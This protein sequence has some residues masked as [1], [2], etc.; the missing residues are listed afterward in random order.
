MTTQ[1]ADTRRRRAG[2]RRGHADRAGQAAIDQTP[3]RVPR[4]TDPPTEPLGPEGVEA[5][6]N[7]AMRILSEI[8][9]VF[10]NAEAREV[11]AK[12][13]A[14]LIDETVFFDPDMVMETIA[15]APASFQIVPRNTARTLTVGDGHILFGNVSSPPNA[16]DMVRGKRPGDFDSFVELIKLTQYFNCIHFAGGYPVEPIDVHASV[17]HLDCLYEKLT[18]TDKV[19]HAYSLGAER[20]EDVMEMVRIAGGLT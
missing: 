4:N 6:H 19:A 1:T 9:I 16:W 11:M 14:K 20:V 18:L 7:G 8:G 3:W 12:A 17:R 10:L 5:I 2:G 13:G 15:Q